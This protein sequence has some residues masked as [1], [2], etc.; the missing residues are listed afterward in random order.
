MLGEGIRHSSPRFSTED[1]T[2][3]WTPDVWQGIQVNSIRQGGVDGIVWERYFATF[4]PYAD[5]NAAEAYWDQGCMIFGSGGAPAAVATGLGQTGGMTFSSDG[6]NEGIGVRS[7]TALF[8]LARASKRFAY[9]VVLST[10]TIADTKHGFFVG[11]TEATA[12]SATVPI[13]AAGTLADINLVGFHR[14]EGDGDKL[15]LVYK[16][17]GVTQ[18]TTVADAIDLAA[19]TDVRLGITYDNLRPDFDTNDS[20]IMRWWKNGRV[21]ASGYKKIP[22]TDGDDF[23]NDV[24]LGFGFSLLNATASTPGTTTLRRVRIA[25]ER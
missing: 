13:A 22:N 15:D 23:P 20:Y 1:T 4:K 24:S 3:D 25:Q 10:S 8:K 2:S 19:D 11:L 17:N 21:I 5:V 14:L 9:E 6:D 16:A 12:F 18:V 7:N